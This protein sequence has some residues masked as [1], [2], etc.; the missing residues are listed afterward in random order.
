MSG[1][2]HV[3]ELASKRDNMP[4]LTLLPAIIAG[5]IRLF[6]LADPT[7]THPLFP[8]FFLQPIYRLPRSEQDISINSSQLIKNR[9]AKIINP[10]EV[11]SYM[12]K[13]D[14]SILAVQEA[15]I[16]RATRDDAKWMSH[17]DGRFVYNFINQ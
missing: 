2:G 17:L 1:G 15:L 11:D 12:S 13:F 4:C 6:T 7:L 3:S 9:D 8:I 16:D 10:F 14:N 5:Q